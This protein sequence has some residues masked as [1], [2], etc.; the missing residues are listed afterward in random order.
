[1]DEEE[2]EEEP[3]AS[4]GPRRTR[5]RRARQIGPDGERLPI[6]ALR[7]LG[8]IAK[9]VAV[10]GAKGALGLFDYALDLD[11]TRA[12]AAEKS[13]IEQEYLERL[14]EVKNRQ[15]MTGYM[16][17]EA[18]KKWIFGLDREK[19]MQLSLMILTLIPL[20]TRT[21]NSVWD[22]FSCRWITYWRNRRGVYVKQPRKRVS[23]R[24]RV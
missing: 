17:A 24:R 16:D 2:E 6:T 12:A 3:G 1:M 18:H 15:A 5:T 21:K 11:G 7:G 4:A 20:S 10:K 8:N 19:H 23:R 9:N 13:R 22:D 14:A